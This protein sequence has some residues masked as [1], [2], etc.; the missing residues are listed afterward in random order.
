MKLR[1]L[2]I[3]EIRHLC[4]E[5]N[6]EYE[7]WKCTHGI[8]PKTE[9]QTWEWAFSRGASAMLAHL[10]DRVLKTIP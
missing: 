7:K 8:S 5:S 4:D 2:K 1:D 6:Q 3:E 10:G 9:Q